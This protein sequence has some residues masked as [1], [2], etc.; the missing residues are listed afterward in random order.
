VVARVKNR[1]VDAAPTCGALAGE[2]LDFA[3]VDLRN[4]PAKGETGLNSQPRTPPAID[5]EMTRR[6][7]AQA[8]QRSPKN[9]RMA[10]MMTI[11]PTM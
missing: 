4:G 8:I 9:D 3:V 1:G 10:M 11:A 6:E 7:K 2:K 5:E